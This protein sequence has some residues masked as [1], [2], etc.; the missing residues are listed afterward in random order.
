MIDDA[1]HAFNDGH[2][3]AP[4]FFYCSRNTAE[5]A[6]SSPDAIVATIAMQLSIPRPG[7]PL[8]PPTVAAY[9]KWEMEAFASGPFRISESCELIIQLIEHYPM[10]TIVIDA[11]DE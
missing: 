8:L 3:P 9:H 11:L 5:P 2:S 10:T 6:R 4:A 7:H 1:K